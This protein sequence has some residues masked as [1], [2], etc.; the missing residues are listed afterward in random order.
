MLAESKFEFVDGSASAPTNLAAAVRTLGCKRVGSSHYHHYAKQIQLQPGPSSF[1]NSGRWCHRSSDG[2][3]RAEEV[4]AD[5]GWVCQ[6]CFTDDYDERIDHTDIVR[7]RCNF[8]GLSCLCHVGCMHWHVRSCP[9]RPEPDSDDSDDDYEM[10]CDESEKCDM[11][12]AWYHV[13]TLSR[14]RFA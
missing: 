4:V 8:C 12:K 2:E 1:L 10:R 3:V 11:D 7:R 13:T 5:L 6:L 14:L 9:E